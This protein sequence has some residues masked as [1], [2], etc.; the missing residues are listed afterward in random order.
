MAHAVRGFLLL[1]VYSGG[2][3]AICFICHFNAP[4]R[5]FNSGRYPILP[6]LCVRCTPCLRPLGVALSPAPWLAAC[7]ASLPPPLRPCGLIDGWPLIGGAVSAAA[8][9]GPFM[10]AVLGLLWRASLPKS[11]PES[12]GK[13]QAPAPKSLILPQN[14]SRLQNSVY[15]GGILLAHFSKVNGKSCKSRPVSA[16]FT[17]KSLASMYLRWSCSGVKPS[18]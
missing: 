4:V 7:A 3:S 17:S 10:P 18:S 15:K 6:L 14:H 2:F 11:L 8:G 16:H 12:P 9:S 1:S 13:S 5:R